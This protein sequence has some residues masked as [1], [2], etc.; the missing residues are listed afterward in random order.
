M[1][2]PASSN[3]NCEGVYASLPFLSSI[4]VSIKC[5]LTT[6]TNK[7]NPQMHMWVQYLVECCLQRTRKILKI[8]FGMPINN[9][10]SWCWSQMEC[11]S[12]P[13]SIPHALLWSS[14]SRNDCFLHSSFPHWHFYNKNTSSPRIKMPI[15]FKQLFNILVSLHFAINCSSMHSD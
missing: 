1:K 12:W 14:Q 9:V 10:Q 4:T 2:L 13:K 15:F 8:Q 6:N 3:H 11:A 5:R 7:A